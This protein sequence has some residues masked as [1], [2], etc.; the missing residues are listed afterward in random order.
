MVDSLLV[1]DRALQIVGLSVMKQAKND[2]RDAKSAGKIE[3]LSKFLYIPNHRAACRIPASRVFFLRR[4][5]V[6]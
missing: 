5:R 1:S 3:K 2:M 6:Q 4:L